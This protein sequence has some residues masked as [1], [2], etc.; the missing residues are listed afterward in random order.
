M[1]LVESPGV[2]APR[3]TGL[4]PRERGLEPMKTLLVA[5][6]VLA[7]ASVAQ[8]GYP[9]SDAMALFL[10]SQSNSTEDPDFILNTSTPFEEIELHLLIVD[11]SRQG[12]AGWEGIVE[13]TG[14]LTASSWT[15]TAGLDVDSANDTDNHE[16]FQVGIG[17]APLALEPNDADN[18]VLATFSAFV[19][20]T[21]DEVEFF[22]KG[23]PGTTSFEPDTPGYASPIDAGDLVASVNPVGD[24]NLP[25]FA[26]N[27]DPGIV[28]NEDMTFSNVKALY[29]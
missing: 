29:R 26:I 18:V 23:V 8:A 17:L 28:S 5:L 27:T 12:V 6:T 13:Y 21:T 15:L 7:L 14:S 11:P 16:R 10:S 1:P 9:G 22:I 20:A 3:L 19:L 4:K 24:E 25:V 2:G